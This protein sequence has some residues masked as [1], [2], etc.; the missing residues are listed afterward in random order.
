MKKKE[1]EIAENLFREP[2]G[3]LSLAGSGGKRAVFLLHPGPFAF[4]GF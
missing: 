2:I 3:R 1:A 4:G